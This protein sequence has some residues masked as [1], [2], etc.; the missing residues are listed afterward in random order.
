[1]LIVYMVL[2]SKYMS[3]A[4][5]TEKSKIDRVSENRVRG[6]RIYRRVGY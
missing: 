3:T 4:F 6:V 1:M 2:S 5:R